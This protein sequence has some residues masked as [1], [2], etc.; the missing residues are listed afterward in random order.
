MRYMGSK[1]GIGKTISEFISSMCPPDTVDG[2]LEPFCGSLGVFQHMTN[3]GYKKII[4]SDVQP[5]LIELWKTIQSNKLKLPANISEKEYNKIKL[6]KSPNAMKAIAG[7]GLSFGGKY[8]AG[9]A[10]KWAG[11]SERNYLQ[12]LKNGLEKLKPLI[13]AKNIKFYN[14][15]YNYYSPKNMLIYCDPPY[16]NTQ[17]YASTDNFD[18]EEF[19]NTMRKWAKNNCVFVSEETAP[20][21]FKSVWSK[22]KYRSLDSKSSFYVTEHLFMYKGSLNKNKTKRLKELKNKTRKSH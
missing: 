11:N 16:K 1:Y 20:K 9:Y 13:S 19:W 6:Y 7:F 17:N 18:H 5:D 21:D 8:F 2:Y 3:K 10:Q 15:S 4:A 14:R 22:K 12:E